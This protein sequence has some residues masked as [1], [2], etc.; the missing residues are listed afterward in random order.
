MIQS[1]DFFF[2]FL[3]VQNFKIRR[4]LTLLLLLRYESP[5]VTQ[6]FSM[7]MMFFKYGLTFFR[8]IL[9]IYLFRKFDGQFNSQTNFI[10]QLYWYQFNQY[11]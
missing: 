8:L 11:W 9:T 2:G 7:A 6:K 1:P 5:T 10:D 3:E 4:F